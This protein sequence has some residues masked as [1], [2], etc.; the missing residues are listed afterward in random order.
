MAYVRLQRKWLDD[1][2]TPTLLY[3]RLGDQPGQFLL[4]SAS[5]E[6]NIGRYS[7]IG[8]DP[9]VHIR[10]RGPQVQLLWHDGRLEH[11]VGDPLAILKKLLESFDLPPLVENDLPFSG[12]AVGYLGYDLVRHVEPLG[13]GPLDDRDL[14]DM[15]MVIPRVLVALDH[16]KRHIILTIL[17]DRDEADAE[18]SQWEERLRRKEVVTEPTRIASSYPLVGLWS[19][20]EY[21]R[22]LL[23]AKEYIAAGDIFQVVLSQRFERQTDQD[24][25]TIYRA[26]R[27]INP[28]PYNFY[29]NFDRLKL[30]GSS[31]EVMVKVQKGKI[32]LKPIAGTRPRSGDDAEDARREKELLADEKEL[33]EHLMLIDLGRNDVGKVSK[34]GTVSVMDPFHIERYSHVLHLVSEVQGELQEDAD[35]FDVFRAALPAGTL[36]GAPKVRAMEI[37][38]ELEPVRRGIY[39]GAVGYFSFDGQMDTCITIRTIAMVDKKCYLQ[40]GGGIVWDSVPS[41]EYEECSSK[42]RAL[43]KAIDLAEEGNW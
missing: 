5:G 24:P 8:L 7:F 26:L 39:G 2:L 37:I 40:A 21:E 34:I 11:Q 9:I 15:Q 12:G 3:R 1:E 14:Y 28:S 29:L 42:A 19:Q 16:F 25:F 41:T 30:L 38:D 6:G 43:V 27:S 32:T 36:S 17:A 4:E 18:L 22:A 20:A 33:A 13:P 23:M 35:L 31:P 10:S